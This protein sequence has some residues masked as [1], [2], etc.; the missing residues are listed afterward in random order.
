MQ[1]ISSTQK[2]ARD[3]GNVLIYEHAS[4]GMVSYEAQGMIREQMA[5]ENAWEKLKAHLH[6]TL[7]TG[8]IHSSL[9]FDQNTV[10]PPAAAGGIT[11]F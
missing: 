5:Y 1:S 7:L 4:V 8:S 11:V 2:R 10:M 3:D 6:I 9:Y